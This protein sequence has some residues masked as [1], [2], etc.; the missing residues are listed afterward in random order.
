MTLHPMRHLPA[1]LLLVL[2][3]VLTWVTWSD[4]DPAPVRV[5]DRV[6]GLRSITWAGAIS[7]DGRLAV[8]ITY[9]LGD[10]E[11][12][13]LSVRLPDGA[14]SFAVNDVPTEASSGVYATVPVA[15]VATVSYELP[16]AVTRYRDGAVLTMLRVKDGSLDG[17]GALFPCPRCYLDPSGY[18]DVP[19]TGS[20]SVPGAENVRL[21]FVQLTSIRSAASATEVR[22]A[23][24]DRTG[25]TVA[26]LAT[27]PSE[28][29]PNLPVRDGTVAKAVAATTA[30]I[31]DAGETLHR[32]GIPEHGS[33]PGA[34]LMTALLAAMVAWIV[35]RAVWSKGASAA[36]RAA[37]TPDPVAGMRA[38]PPDQLEPALVGAV[39]GKSARGDRSA[40]AATLVELARR[41]VITFSGNDDRRFTVTVPAGASGASPFEQAVLSGL[42]SKQSGGSTVEALVLVAP[43]LWGPDGAAVAKRLWRVLLRESMRQK[44]TR[45]SPPAALLVPLTLAIGVLGIGGSIG[46]AVFAWIVTIIGGLIAIGLASSRVVVLTSRGRAEQAEWTDYATWLRSDAGNG[47]LA[48]ADPWDVATVG[49]TLA[50]ATALGAAPRV[51]RLL[52]PRPEVQR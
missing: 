24:I 14:R 10:D 21:S 19:L 29:V 4:V 31:R 2:L 7:P 48:D 12:R 47:H 41:G 34:I 42:R 23:G 43:P 27:L 26:L 16:G 38:V 32:P 25:E 45:V 40:V 18:G 17:D 8:R 11:Q 33:R 36:Q 22:F 15:G 13:Q 20:L 9:D 35:L 5:S 50:Y 44:L 28:V 51:A 1:A 46:G 6:D 37:G 30:Q 39:V 52:S 3:G 49:E